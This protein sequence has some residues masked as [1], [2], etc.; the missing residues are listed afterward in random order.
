MKKISKELQHQIDNLS[1]VE[2][3]LIVDYILTDLDLP[4]PEVDKAWAKEVVRRD[5]MVK[6]GKMK[7][8]PYETVMK[9]YL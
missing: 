2:K 1:D 3:L 4:D 7:T 6:S 5:K 9:K 8:I